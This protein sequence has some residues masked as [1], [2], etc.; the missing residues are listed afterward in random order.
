M[1]TSIHTNLYMYKY[2]YIYTS[3][4]TY[5]QVYIGLLTS[6]PRFRSGGL[7]SLEVNVV[8][9]YSHSFSS[10][11]LGVPQNFLLAHIMEIP[12]FYRQLFP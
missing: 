10:P 7:W 3:I 5:I 6:S 2:I 1:Y 4:Y 11:D 12:F 9:L 8:S